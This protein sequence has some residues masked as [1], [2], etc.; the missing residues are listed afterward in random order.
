[1]LDVLETDEDG[2]SD[3]VAQFERLGFED[4]EK[5]AEDDDDTETDDD[6]VSSNEA[7]ALAL[8]PK[9][10]LDVREDISSDVTVPEAVDE[11]L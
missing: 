8:S 3:A 1:L 10:M 9:D 7:T 4:V 11:R 6:F 5:H 2:V